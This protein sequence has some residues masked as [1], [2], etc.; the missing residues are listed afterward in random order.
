MFRSRSIGLREPALEAT[1]G[2]MDCFFGQL[3][4]KRHLDATSKRWHLWDIDLRF[5]RNSTPGRRAG[6]HPQDMVFISHRHGSAPSAK[7]PFWYVTN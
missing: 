7:H 6:A 1:Q 2:Q 4:Y 5:A 3:P